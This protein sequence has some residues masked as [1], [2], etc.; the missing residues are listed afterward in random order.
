MTNDKRNWGEMAQQV[1]ELRENR[2]QSAGNS[3]MIAEEV[4]EERAFSTLSADRQRKVMLELRYK[5]GNAKALAYCY[6]VGIDFNPSK[7]IVM[8]FSAY[9][10]RI[11]GRNLP[12]L[13]SGLVAQ[14]IAFV[15]EA[16]DLYAEMSEEP[17]TTI[18]TKIEVRETKAKE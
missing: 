5:T 18:V 1:S 15:Q 17:D 4:A 8:D 2:N 3:E 11:S 10:V 6:L 16:D 13:F 14:R 12:S 7:E 9:E